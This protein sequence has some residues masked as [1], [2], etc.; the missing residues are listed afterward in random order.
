MCL[1]MHTNSDECVYVRGHSVRGECWKA[2][3]QDLI[4]YTTLQ[5]R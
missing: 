1:S 2:D 3:P 5:I 4:L